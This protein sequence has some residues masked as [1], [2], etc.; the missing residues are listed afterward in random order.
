MK[1]LR[2]TIIFLVW[3]SLSLIYNQ[4]Y[5]GVLSSL[6]ASDSDKH[7]DEFQK[8]APWLRE[9][10]QGGEPR[11]EP[12]PELYLRTPEKKEEKEDK[13]PYC[14]Y[15]YCQEQYPLCYNPDTGRYEYCY[16]S[17]SSYFQN[18]FHSPKFRLWWQ[19]ERMCPPGYFFKPGLGCVRF[20]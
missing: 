12:Q 5:I 18:R 3:L 7:G 17:D 11:G 8:Q 19:K 1:F 10:Q 4:Q 6:A 9:K 14:Y 2:I 15:P 20:R 13:Y 16:P